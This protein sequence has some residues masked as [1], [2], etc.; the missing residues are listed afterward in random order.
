[1]SRA[2]SLPGPVAARN[3]KARHEYFIEDTMEAGIVLAGTEVKSLR[4]G[5]ANITDAYAAEEGGELHLMNAYIAEYPAAN[6]FNHETRRPR[7]LLLHR[8][9]VDRLLG[10]VRRQGMTLVPL[11]IYFNEKGRAKVQLALARGKRK[12][13]K[14]AVEKER[15]WQREKERLLR[16]RD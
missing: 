8:R 3:R 5:R 11:A 1:M 7:K 9:Q 14:R 2:G 16:A 4:E 13:D 10:A 6:R 12:Y 15:E